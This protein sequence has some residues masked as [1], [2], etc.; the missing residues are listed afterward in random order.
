MVLHPKAD[1]TQENL[2]VLYNT[3]RN[4]GVYSSSGDFRE[5]GRNGVFWVKRKVYSRELSPFP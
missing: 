3:L 2:N 4:K 1:P 5:G